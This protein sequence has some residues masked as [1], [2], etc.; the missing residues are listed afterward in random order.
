M[1]DDPQGGPVWERNQA[2][3]AIGHA[4]AASDPDALKTAAS[5]LGDAIING[6]MAE[7]NRSMLDHVGLVVRHELGALGGTQE[8]RW[9]YTLGQLDLLIKKADAQY[10]AYG[11]A[12]ERIEAALMGVGTRLGKL[13]HQMQDSQEDRSDLRS[14]QLAQGDQIAALTEQVTILTEQFRTYIDAVPLERRNA[15][16]A[17]IEDHERRLNEIQH[18]D[19]G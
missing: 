1:S 11:A 17:Q 10:D 7:Y 6:A 2:A 15:L 9:N 4:L 13:E 14:R 12:L 16:V 19:E 3:D 8:H 5:R 18:G